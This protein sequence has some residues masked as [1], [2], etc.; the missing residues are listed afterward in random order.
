MQRYYRLLGRF[1]T[2]SPHIQRQVLLPRSVPA[3]TRRKTTKRL[4]SRFLKK[5]I[6]SLHDYRKLP[7]KDH[8]LRSASVMPGVPPISLLF[9]LQGDELGA[10][11]GENEKRSD[12]LVNG[13]PRASF[14]DKKMLFILPI[15][16]DSISRWR[17]TGPG[18]MSP[19][20]DKAAAEHP[21]RCAR[22]RTQ[23]RCITLKPRE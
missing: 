11:Y 6:G 12:R 9:F 16:L 21:P 15:P 10:S 20:P 1:R 7:R 19:M 8:T 4:H 2:S 23:Q 22:A 14:R 13:V 17:S 5:P 3:S 18:Q